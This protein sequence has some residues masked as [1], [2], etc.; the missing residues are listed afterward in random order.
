MKRYLLTAMEY[1]YSEIE[2]EAETEQDAIDISID[3]R[4]DEWETINSDRWHIETVEEIKD[5]D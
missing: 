2:V 5:D 3:E 1:V 4:F